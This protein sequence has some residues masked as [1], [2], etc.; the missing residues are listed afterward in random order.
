M[1]V[2]RQVG[3]RLGGTKCPDACRDG[4]WPGCPAGEGTTD[5]HAPWMAV[6]VNEAVASPEKPRRGSPVVAVHMSKVLGT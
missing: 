5:H 4:V 1:S 2:A 3:V 6:D